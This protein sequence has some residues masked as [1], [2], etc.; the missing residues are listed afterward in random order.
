MALECTLLYHH[1]FISIYNLYIT[2]AVATLAIFLLERSLL[3]TNFIL[4][5]ARLFVICTLKTE[6]LPYWLVNLQNYNNCNL[7]MCFPVYML[8][9]YGAC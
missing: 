7:P 3:V 5:K 1:V 9:C 2:I 8:L 6:L 4:N